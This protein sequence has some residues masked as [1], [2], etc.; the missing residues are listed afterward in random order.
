MT[1]NNTG[2]EQPRVRVFRLW[3]EATMPLR[4]KDGK[5]WLRF[6]DSVMGFALG[7]LKEPDFSD[8]GELEELWRRTKVKSY[9]PGKMGYIKLTKKEARDETR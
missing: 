8:D 6:Y 3:Y 4:K 2:Y 7:N 9:S 5:R 1:G